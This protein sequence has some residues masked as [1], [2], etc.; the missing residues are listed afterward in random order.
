MLDQTFGILGTLLPQKVIA[1]SGDTEQFDPDRIDAAIRRMCAGKAD[2][3]KLTRDVLRKLAAVGAEVVTAHYLREL[4]AMELASIGLE[5]ESKQYLH[6][7]PKSIRF[8]LDESFIDQYRDQQPEW[9]PLGYI[10]YKRTYARWIENEDRSEEFWETLRRVVEGCFSIQKQHCTSLGY[11]WDDDEGQRKARTMYEKMWN[12]KFLAP[13]R[14]LWVMGTPFIEQHGSMALNN[15][16]FVSTSDIDIKVSMPFEWAMDALMLGV[17]VGFDVRGANK[18]T[19]QQPARDGSL[20][21]IPD[22]REGWTQSLG[23]L[24]RAYFTGSNLPDFD[25][26]VI[27]PAGSPIRGFGG[28]SAGPVPLIG[29]HEN[30]AALLGGRIGAYLSVSDIT[31]IFNL[32]AKCVVAGNVRRSA[33][34]ALGNLDDEEFLNLKMDPI[35]AKH[36]RWASN[37]SVFAK[38]GDNYE[39]IVERI[40]Q[41]GEPGIVWLD[42]VRVYSRLCDNPD[43]KDHQVMGVNPCGEQALESY[44]LC[45]LVETF[46]S[47]H[48]S[49]EEYEETL[50]YAY[51]YAKAVTLINTHWRITNAVMGKNRRI[52]CSQSGIIDAFARHG[53]RT[54]I[55]WCKKGYAFL[56]NLDKIYSDWL[57]VPRS[58][59]ITSVKPS[60]TISLLPG[61]SPGI[62]YPHSEYYIR[63]MRVQ[64]DSPLLKALV[65]G[66]YDIED[67]RNSDNTAVVSFPIHEQYFSRSKDDITVWEQLQN[68]ADYQRFWADNQV[69]I[70]V[71]FKPHEDILAALE[72]FEDKLKCVSFLPLKEH[73]YVQAPYE[74]ITAE[75]YEDM[76]SRIVP[77]ELA[78]Q[79]SGVKFCDNT[80]CE[81]EEHTQPH[82]DR[83]ISCGKLLQFDDPGPICDECQMKDEANIV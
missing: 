18:I 80:E 8:L 71:T 74:S 19:I 32:I 1:P 68:A 7:V 43:N 57:G 2:V 55:E 79:S 41:N 58:I 23:V 27:R 15:C 67:D 34:I 49:Y 6:T 13:G 69:S 54:M 72:C 35:L 31:D 46:P 28:T 56:Q 73:G 33:E 78:I 40:R 63:R 45:C 36:H 30:I 4:I 11:P 59:K 3:N 82:E 20:F 25:Y 14:G 29:M 38:V 62:H 76:V 16:G 48:E 10:T 50:K 5:S 22:S 65:K 12:F 37:N 26:S 61:V 24:L 64:K 60:G 52:G 83:C 81:L 53:R 51:L 42:A 17:G 21:Q 70:T 75:H 44:E 9:G 47:R 39:S 77:V 66:G